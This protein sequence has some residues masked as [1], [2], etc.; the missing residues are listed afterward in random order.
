MDA[1]DVTPDEVPSKPEDESSGRVFDPVAA[2]LNAEGTGRVA[3]Q[4]D[5]DADSGASATAD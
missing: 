1:E 5:D 3:E 2:R 4:T